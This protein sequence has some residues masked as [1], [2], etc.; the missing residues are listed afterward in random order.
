[1]HTDTATLVVRSDSGIATLDDIL[2]RVVNV[3]LPGSPHRATAGELLERHGIDISEDIESRDFLHVEAA[4]SQ[5]NGEIDAFFSSSPAHDPDVAEASEQVDIRLI[6]L[7]T[8][9][10]ALL[11]TETPYYS[12]ARIPTG[13][14]RPFDP[15]DEAFW[16]RTVDP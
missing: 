3:G 14:Y 11:A 9:S 5:V 13:H 16:T 8:E 15:L 12:P 7:D 10:A 1:M 6:P 2:G 4:A